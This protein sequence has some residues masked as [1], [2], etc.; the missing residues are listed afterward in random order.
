MICRTRRRRWSTSDASWTTCYRSPVWTPKRFALVGH[1]FGGMYGA[2][3]GNLDR[4]PTQYVLMAATPRFPDWYL[5]WPQ[6]GGRGSV[7]LYP[8]HCPA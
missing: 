1:D 3:A 6:A 4:R 7:G 2:L 8:C 5:Y